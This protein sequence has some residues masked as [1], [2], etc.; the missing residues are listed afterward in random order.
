MPLAELL[1][2][3]REEGALLAAPHEPEPGARGDLLGAA[4]GEACASHAAGS[5]RQRGRQLYLKD[6]HFCAEFPDY[7][8]SWRGWAG[9]GQLQRL[10][11]AALLP[12]PIAHVAWCPRA[13]APPHSHT[14][15]RPTLLTTG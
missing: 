10:A 7:G 5:A 13:R 12:A 3:W 6:W 1:A 15:C 8:V 14:P 2:L 4:P 9:A 11:A